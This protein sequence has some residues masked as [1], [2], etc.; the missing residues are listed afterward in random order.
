MNTEHNYELYQKKI[1]TLLHEYPELKK[2]EKMSAH[3]SFLI[4]GTADLFYEVENL[5]K[6]IKLLKRAKD[7]DIPIQILG[8]GSNV[9]ISDKG[10][11]GLVCVFAKNYAKI[12]LLTASEAAKKNLTVL[13]V[14]KENEALSS[15]P[16]V[17]DDVYF[18]EAESGISLAAVAEFAAQNSLTGLEFARGIPGSLGGALYMNAGAYGD[19]MQDVVSRT[20][21]LTENLEI[22]DIDYENH[23]FAYRESVFSKRNYI[24]LSS[25]L[26][27]RKGD[28]EKIIARM[29][30]LAKRRRDSQP[31][32]Y[33]SAGSVFK[34]PEG[35]YAGKLIMD[36]GLKGSS[37]GGAEVSTKHAGF[38]INKNKQASA[39]DVLQLIKKVQETVYSKY[40]V[41]LER[42][43]RL[44][45][46]FDGKEAE[47]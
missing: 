45:G 28:Y 8:K 35:Y 44:I 21:V 19:M 20:R 26:C 10:I 13:S 42:E 38:I 36:S 16:D 1:E 4:G 12:N 29:A 5:E 31:L 32:E 27:L 17:C 18:I 37:V 6:L 47:V 14:K 30:E 2:D 46:D 3:C 9:L 39:E 25:Y 34:R 33:P 24:I 11:R 43:L 7:L 22:V 40:S 15:M 41:R 23:E